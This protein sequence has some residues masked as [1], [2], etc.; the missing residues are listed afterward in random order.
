MRTFGHGQQNF[1][2]FN[3]PDPLYITAHETEYDLYPTNNCMRRCCVAAD[4]HSYA[5]YYCST[6]LPRSIAAN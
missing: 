1:L 6:G 4:E 5:G 3:G 2:L